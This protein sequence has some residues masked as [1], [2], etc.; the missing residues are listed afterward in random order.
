M[1]PVRRRRHVG[2]LLYELELTG[3]ERASL[4]DELAGVAE[5]I[6]ET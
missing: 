6:D 1:P 3:E 2:R 4:A 5:L